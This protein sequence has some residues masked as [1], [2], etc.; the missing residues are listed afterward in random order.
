MGWQA[1]GTLEGP[2]DESQRE[3]NPS[4]ARQPDIRKRNR[5]L[6]EENDAMVQNSA[7][8]FE[9]YSGMPG[10]PLIV[11]LATELNRSIPLT[12]GHLHC[13]WHRVNQVRPTGD[14]SDK[15]S[16]EI[17]EWAQWQGPPGHFVQ[18]LE[19]VRLLLRVDDEVLLCDVRGR[20]HPSLYPKPM[21]LDYREERDY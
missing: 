6:S 19:Q 8:W 11:T 13:L 5:H 16:K 21:K 17:E 3:K 18:A 14:L 1:L 4:I 20:P 7:P 2:S 9:C 10:S 12:V 15:S